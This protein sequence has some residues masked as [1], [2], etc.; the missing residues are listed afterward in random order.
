MTELIISKHKGGHMI[1]IKSK[2]DGT[3]LHESSKKSIRLALEEAVKEGADLEGANLEG[4]NLED[5]DLRDANLEDADLKGA[6]GLK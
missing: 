2:I 1:Q 5:A 3:V 4:A 6:K